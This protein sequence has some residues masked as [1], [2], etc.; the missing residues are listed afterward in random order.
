M[1][2]IK[3]LVRITTVPLSIDTLLKGQLGFMNSFYDVTAV[4]SDHDYLARCAKTEKVKFRHIE[5]T[6]KITP[7]KDLIA[8][9]KLFY[10]FKNEKPHIVHSH[11]P[12]AGLLAMIAAKCA[13]VPIRLHTVGGM[14][15]METSGLKRKVLQLVEK[16]TYYCA[17]KIFPNSKGLY[18]FILDSDL[19]TPEKLKFMANGS[20]NGINTAHFSPDSVS[21]EVQKSLKSKL[22]IAD[23][24]FVIV[25]VGRMV[26][27]KGINELALAFRN[28]TTTNKKL[29]L[30][31]VGMQESVDPLSKVTQ[32]EIKE[33]ENIIAVGFQSDIRPYL[34]ISNALILPTY[35]EGFPNVVLQAGAMGL[36]VIVTDINGCNEI[37]T[38][39]KNGIIIPVKNVL[40]IELAILEMVNDKAYYNA[41]KVN[42][43]PMITSRYEQHIMWNAILQEYQSHEKEVMIKK[44]DKKFKLIYSRA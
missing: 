4:S 11:T 2:E 14:P 34:A 15:L 32:K 20:T 41:L 9:V 27:D 13:G 16:L 6:R 18:D 19:A 39:G 7:A 22:E 8:L 43:R 33:N 24:D 26:G 31:F 25:F 42:A 21:Q 30:L 37:V 28:V 17:N 5:M 44:A 3:K 29:K 23:D 35:R 36:P 40:E 10:F 1:T 38:N 12:K